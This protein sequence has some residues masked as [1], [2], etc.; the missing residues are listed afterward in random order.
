MRTGTPERKEK[1]GFVKM[2]E[3]NDVLYRPYRMCA[4]L[5]VK[6]RLLCHVA[7]LKG[8]SRQAESTY[9]NLAGASAFQAS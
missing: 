9:L 1:R 5:S 3:G 4:R 2:S 7:G 6:F 8:D